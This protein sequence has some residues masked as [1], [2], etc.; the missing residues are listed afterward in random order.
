MLKVLEIQE[1][2][3][4]K[5]ELDEYITLKIRWPENELSYVDDKLYWHTGDLKSSLLEIGMSAKTGVLRSLTIV[6]VKSVKFGTFEMTSHNQTEY[7]LPIFCTASWPGTK[8]EPKPETNNTGS[9]NRK[10]HIFDQGI[11]EMQCGIDKI[12]L[13]ISRKA[14]QKSINSGRVSFGLDSENCVANIVVFDLCED[15]M[16]KIVDTIK[17]QLPK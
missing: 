13:V 5:I 8:P 12:D 15:E 6:S 1:P 7:G 17:N 9:R 10:N 16:N 4:E 11:F 2:V 3:H 14:C